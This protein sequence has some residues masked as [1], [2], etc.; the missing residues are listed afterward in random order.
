M[1]ITS[2]SNKKL[3]RRAVVLAK[4][5]RQIMETLS[6]SVTTRDLN[7]KAKDLRRANLIPLEYY[8]TGVKNKSLQVD[9][10]T[11]RK[12]YR[13]TGTSAV[14]ELN[15]DDK[16]KINVLVHDI[17]KDP[18]TDHIIHVDLINVRMDQVL[19]THIPLE[20]T[21]VCPAVK[22][23]G[24]V[25]THKLTEIDVK[26]LPKDLVH[27]I[28]VSVEPIV[29]YH[30]FVRVKNLNI[31]AGITVLN[32]PEEVVAS[33]SALRIEEEETAT[34]AIDTAAAEGAVAA[35]VEGATTEGAPAAVSEAKGKKE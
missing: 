31:P 30:T 14:I 4:L 25:L 11:F 20:F 19:H 33:A 13:T 35:P 1:L 34:S 8:G 7:Q 23:L 16:E 3:L 28:T 18:V 17:D 10:Q 6:L 26:C 21:G 24:G 2:G 12:L 5:G 27:S 15:I 22:E 29:D 9:Y 32:D